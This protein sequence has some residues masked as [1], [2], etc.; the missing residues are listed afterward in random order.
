MANLGLI[1][2]EL[3]LNLSMDPLAREVCM[4]AGSNQIMGPDG[5]MEIMQLSNGYF[6]PDA[7]AATR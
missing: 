1:E 3:A 6:A 4:A 5:L 2:R 7:A